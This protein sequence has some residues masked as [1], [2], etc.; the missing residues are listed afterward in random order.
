MGLANDNQNYKYI[1][2]AAQWIYNVERMRALDN[3][4]P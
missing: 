1:G 3:I 4:E 2:P